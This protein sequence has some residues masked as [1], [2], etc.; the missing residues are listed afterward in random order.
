MEERWLPIPGYDGYEVSDQG[1]VRSYRQRVKGAG[2]RWCARIIDT[3]KLLKPMKLRVGYLA[4]HLYNGIGGGNR[5]YVH[6]MVAQAFLDKPSDPTYTLATHKNGDKLD[7][8]PA[9]L[10]WGNNLTNQRDRLRH[11]SSNK[12][13]KNGQSKLTPG[14]VS[15]IRR[16]HAAGG[17]PTMQGLGEEFGVV[18][19]TISAIV[20]RVTWRHIE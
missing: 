19:Q 10:A 13:E 8:R 18:Y 17:T 6:R 15:E 16:R 1:R 9:N 7:N 5:V 4:C 20:R 12:R 14:Q 3:P 2:G 11:G